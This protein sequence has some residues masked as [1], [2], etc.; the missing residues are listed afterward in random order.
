MAARTE[1]FWVVL[2]SRR[3]C[4]PENAHLP[5]IFLLCYWLGEDVHGS[6]TEKTHERRRQETSEGKGRAKGADQS[7]VTWV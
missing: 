1:E 2:A 6:P 4:F 7:L 3:R 5:L